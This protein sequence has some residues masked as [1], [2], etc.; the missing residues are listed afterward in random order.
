[1]PDIF[2]DQFQRRDPRRGANADQG[3]DALQCTAPRIGG[4]PVTNIGNYSS[5]TSARLRLEPDVDFITLNDTRRWS[6]ADI[7]TEFRALVEQG[8]ASPRP[9]PAETR[10]HGC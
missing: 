6:P 8:P 10:G 4:P 7:W 2:P 3:A 5:P 1:M 9:A